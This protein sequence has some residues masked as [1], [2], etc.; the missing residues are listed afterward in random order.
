[1]QLVRVLRLNFLVIVSDTNVDFRLDLEFSLVILRPS[2]SREDWTS[3]SA[4]ILW[5]AGLRLL[6]RVAL[7]P[8]NEG[9]QP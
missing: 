2:Y 5:H 3:H 9:A 8:G 4:D 6:L 1:M 7:H